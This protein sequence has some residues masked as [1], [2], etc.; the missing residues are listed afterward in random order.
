VQAVTRRRGPQLPIPGGWRRL[1]APFWQALGVVLP[2]RNGLYLIRNTLYFSGNDITEPIIVLSIYVVIGAALVL[3]FSWG[4]LHWKG[5][6]EESTGP[7][8]VIDPDEQIGIAAI[9]P[10]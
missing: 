7:P 2:P 4:H 5:K 3:F 8:E 1:P 6:K 9:P 10:G